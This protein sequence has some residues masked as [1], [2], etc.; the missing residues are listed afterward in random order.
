MATEIRVPTLGESVTEATIGRWFKKAGDAVKADEPLVEL[1]TDKV[2]LEVQRARRRHARRD[3]VKDGRPSR[4][5]ASGSI[6]EGGGGRRPA[7]KPQ[8]RRGLAPKRRRARSRR[9]RRKLVGGVRRSR[10]GRA[11]AGG[12]SAGK[13][14][15]RRASRRRV[16]RRP[17][18]VGGS[19]K[20]GRVTERR[21][22][23]RHRAWRVLR[24][25]RGSAS[26]RQA[27]AP[28]A[29]D[30]A[31]REERVRMTKLRQTIAQRLKDA[32]NTAAMLTTFNEV[33]MSAVMELR[34][35]VQG[36][37]REEARREARLHGLLR[38]GLPSRR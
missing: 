20:D 6:V 25:G 38:E 26:A 34:A 35:T 23:R 11:R 37:V 16:G 27:R 32:Q 24:A 9:R 14:A 8:R 15:G 30:D 21:H 29:P 3:R 28:S 7:P 18:T 1:E 22:A 10:R 12:G 13:P 5:R 4:R 33:D 31:A 2:T 17:A 36:R 19:G